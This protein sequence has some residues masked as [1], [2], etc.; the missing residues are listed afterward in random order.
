MRIAV[1]GGT[2][3]VGRRVVTA[4]AVAGHQTVVLA[5]STGVDLVSGRGL[6][7][8]LA[9]V[10]AVI[11]VTNLTTT[12]RSASVDFF[13]TTSTQLLARAGAP[14]SAHHIALSIVGIDR[15]DLGYYAGKRR[16]EELVL[17]GPVP[18]TVLRATQ[19]HEFAAQLL[20]RGP[21]WLVVAPRMRSQPVAAS[22]VAAALVSLAEGGPLGQGTGARRA[23]GAGPGPARPVA[24]AR[25]RR[26]PL[27][28]PVRVPGAGW[29]GH[30]RGR[31]AADRAWP[32]R[33]ADL[34]RV[35]DRVRCGRAGSGP[36]RQGSRTG[37][38]SRSS[39]S[40]TTTRRRGPG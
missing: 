39:S 16:Q 36:A 27:V 35:A 40:R 23:R 37:P 7:T 34:R 15:V 30:G 1:A 14:V 3:T 18:A 5:R 29:A 20:E 17:D 25:P 2:G 22:E 10:A 24:G 38:M 28:V 31:P 11:D 4:A 8:A 26:A 12:K 33:A 21:R 32:A 13:T 9:G 6:D 19:F